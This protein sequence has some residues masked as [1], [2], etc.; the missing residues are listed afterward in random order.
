MMVT[1]KSSILRTL[2][3]ILMFT[4]GTTHIK[5]TALNDL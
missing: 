4:S 5:S 2:M 1:W 3:G